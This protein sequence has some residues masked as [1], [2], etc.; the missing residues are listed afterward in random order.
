MASKG[1]DKK[2]KIDITGMIGS[3][4]DIERRLQEQLGRPKA[5]FSEDGPVRS[6]T[7]PVKRLC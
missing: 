6:P 2:Q 5:M 4:E 7:S 1:R 3:A